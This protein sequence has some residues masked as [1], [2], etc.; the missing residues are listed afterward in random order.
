MK[1]TTNQALLFCWRREFL[2]TGKAHSRVYCSSHCLL[3]RSPCR[4]RRRNLVRLTWNYLSSFRWF[5]WKQTM[6]KTCYITQNCLHSHCKPITGTVIGQDFKIQK[7]DTMGN[8]IWHLSNGQLIDK[9]Q[10]WWLTACL[11]IIQLIWILTDLLLPIIFVC[12][13]LGCGAFLHS[14]YNFWETHH[15]MRLFG[16]LNVGYFYLVNI[17][18]WVQSGNTFYLLLVETGYPNVIRHVI[19]ICRV[20]AKHSK[21]KFWNIKYST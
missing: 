21:R 4:Y 14:R 19:E 6:T 10:V 8:S 17:L 3:T 12:I 11:I 7:F 15:F 16:E 20:P 13:V 9:T 2:C 1:T 18:L 5:L